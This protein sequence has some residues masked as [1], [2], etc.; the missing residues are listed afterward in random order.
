MKI[1]QKKIKS[2]IKCVF[3]LYAVCNLQGCI[4][5]DNAI[6]YKNGY[7]PGKNNELKFNGFYQTKNK[8]DLFPIFFYNDGSVIFLGYSKDT[9]ELKEH[10]LSNPKGLWGYWGNYKISRDTITIETFPS[11][12][13]E[14][15]QERYLRKGIIKNGSITFYQEINRNHNVNEVNETIEFRDFK[16]KPD[17]TANW[18]RTKKKYNK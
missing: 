13:Q 1:S 7:N 10:I 17:S 14:F 2:S 8:T 4:S 16:T 18:I 12:V 11:N 3:A 5:Y 15:R 9:I 6:L